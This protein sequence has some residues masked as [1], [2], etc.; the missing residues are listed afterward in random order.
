MT[1]NPNKFETFVKELLNVIGG[2][3]ALYGFFITIVFFVIF[4]INGGRIYI[5]TSDDIMK[6]NMDAYFEVQRLA[7]EERRELLPEGER[8]GMM[9]LEINTGWTKGDKG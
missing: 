5:T 3:F 9:T 6:A 2:M 4:Q 8:E 1:N 7:M